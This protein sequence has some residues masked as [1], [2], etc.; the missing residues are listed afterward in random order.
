VEEEIRPG[1]AALRER[2]ARTLDEHRSVAGEKRH[3]RGC[4]TA[5]ENVEDLADRGSFQ[6][7]G[8]LAVAAQRSRRDYRALQSAIASGSGECRA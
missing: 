7:Y 5:R 3:A 6:E 4:R 1:L 8:Q 2:L